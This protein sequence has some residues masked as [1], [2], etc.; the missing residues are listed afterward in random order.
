MKLDSV[1]SLKQEIREVLMGSDPFVESLR[2]VLP[3]EE[4][5]FAFAVG[6]RLTSREGDY[7][8]A[9]RLPRW[10]A[11]FRL[12]RPALSKI[13]RQVRK[14]RD[15]QVI[16]R[17]RFNTAGLAAAPGSL[18]KIGA[19]VRHASGDGGTLGFFAQKGA[20][21]GVVSCNHV[22]ALMD[23][24]QNGDQVFGP[25][26]VELRLDGDYPR[27]RTRTVR[28]ADCAFAAFTNNDRPHDPAQLD[29]AG[30]LLSTPLLP[31]KEMPVKKIGAKTGL[32]TGKVVVRDLDGFSVPIG[33]G[34]SATFN[35]VIEIVS[36]NPK[37]RFSNSGDSG[38]LVYSDDLRPVG[39]LFADT[40]IGGVFRNGR[41]FANRFE[42][43][44]TALGVTLV[45]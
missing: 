17:V 22:L 11:W 39:L 1:R 7:H 8:L 41:S 3:F 20:A 43:V 29:G 33:K 23:A 30:R 40:A 25:S 16:G 32:R 24:G 14:E 18:L 26:S 28:L 15:I 45:V 42:H 44:T 21:F 6:V 2:N 12:F 38:A 35:D 27:L 4:Q 36:D 19:P 5:D 13:L 9:I 31:E 10:A 37:R 34:L